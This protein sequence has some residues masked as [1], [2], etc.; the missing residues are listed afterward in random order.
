MNEDLRKPDYDLESAISNNPQNYDA[1]TIETVLAE[2]PG[3]ND[4]L[5]WHWI[6]KFKPDYPIAPFAYLVGWCD[7]TGWYCSSGLS[8]K[9]AGTLEEAANLAPEKEQFSNRRVR[10]TLLAQLRGQKPYGVYDRLPNES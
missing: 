1:K 6:V 2:V 3:A 10:E 5:S 4:E 9:M 8:A 7:F